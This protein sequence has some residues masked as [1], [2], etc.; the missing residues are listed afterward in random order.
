MTMTAILENHATDYAKLAAKLARKGWAI[1]R[2]EETASL[3]FS[4][5]DDACYRLALPRSEF[6]L[7]LRHVRP[8]GVSH[9]MKV[10]GSAVWELEARSSTGAPVL[11]AVFSS[12]SA[13]RKGNAIDVRQ[14]R[15]REAQGLLILRTIKEAV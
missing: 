10:S 8:G 11:S 3:W 2:D 13:M 12:L 14:E 15:N 7:Y 5:S 6:S 9:G 4:P 1:R